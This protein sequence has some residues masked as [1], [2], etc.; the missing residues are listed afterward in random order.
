MQIRLDP[1]VER[2]VR[3]LSATSNP[4]ISVVRLANVLLTEA[5]AAR[6]KSKRVSAAKRGGAK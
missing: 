4:F 6:T 2:N 1:P 3:L 5:V